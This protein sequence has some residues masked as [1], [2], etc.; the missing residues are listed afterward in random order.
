MECSFLLA[1]TTPCYAGWL[2]D[3]FNSQII[4]SGYQNNAGFFGAALAFSVYF[5]A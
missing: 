4:S 1:T 5:S 2:P 3:K